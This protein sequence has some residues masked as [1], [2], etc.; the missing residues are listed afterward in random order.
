[1]LFPCGHQAKT[2][3]KKMVQENLNMSFKMATVKLVLPGQRVCWHLTFHPLRRAG[4]KPCGEPCGNHS[5]SRLQ[6]A[7]GRSDRAAEPSG[8][9]CLTSPWTLPTGSWTDRSASCSNSSAEGTIKRVDSKKESIK[10][11]MP[12]IKK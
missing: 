3:E 5:S 8:S 6:F 2:H 10:T 12:K 4:L 1:M 7:C 11:R 9:R